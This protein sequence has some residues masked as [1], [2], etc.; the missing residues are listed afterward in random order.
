VLHGIYLLLL[1]GHSW[2]RVAAAVFV[3]VLKN[4]PATLLSVL[5]LGYSGGAHSRFTTTGS[6]SDAALQ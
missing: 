2:C 1:P 6:G 5:W 4:A 3:D